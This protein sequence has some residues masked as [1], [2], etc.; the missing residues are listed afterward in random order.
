MNEW[1][2]FLAGALLVALGDACWLI[3]RMYLRIRVQG[4]RIGDL[5]KRMDIYNGASKRVKKHNGYNENKAYEDLISLLTQ[6]AVSDEMEKSAR[7][8]RIETALAIL[9]ALRH[10]PRNYNPDK[11][12]EDYL[13]ERSNL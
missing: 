3:S 5:E 12:L 9:M 13:K 8:G 4:K 2:Y 1:Y 10:D 7:R 11:S 6:D